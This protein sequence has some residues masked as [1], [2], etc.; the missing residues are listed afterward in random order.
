MNKIFGLGFHKTG[1]TTLESAL[2]SLGIDCVGKHDHLFE[3]I[4]EQDWTAIDK[5]VSMHDAFRDMPWPLFYEELFQRYPNGKFILT[6]RDSQEWIKSCKNH[7]KDNGDILFA[8]IYG[9][10][11]HF[12]VGNEKHWI[13]TYEKHNQ[14]VRDFFNDKSKSF[15]EVD[16]EKGDD[17]DALCKFLNKPVPNRPFPHAN[18]GKYTLL[19]KVMRK[20]EWLVDRKGFRKRNRDL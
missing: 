9:E 3:A 16:W 15:L 6:V 1:S 13:S 19:G 11:R 14:S 2:I 5:A 17:W 10:N 18:K 8:K 7:Y 12:P 4:K 20:I